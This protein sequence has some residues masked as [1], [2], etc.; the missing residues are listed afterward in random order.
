MKER[1]QYKRFMFAL[2]V[3]IETMVTGRKKVLDLATRDISVSG[4]FIATL[5]SFPERTRFILDF[6]IPSDSIKG[7]KDTKSLR[8]Y[9]RSMV[10]STPHGMAINFDRECQIEGLKAL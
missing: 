7:L 6:T 1:R 9:T 5:T 10:R 2:P 4:I 8:G 3:R